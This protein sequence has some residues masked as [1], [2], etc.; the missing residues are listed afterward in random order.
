MQRYQAYLLR[1]SCSQRDSTPHQQRPTTPC[2][3]TM[4]NIPWFLDWATRLRILER[5]SSSWS[6]QSAVGGS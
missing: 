4:L 5:Y 1:F 2:T 6:L 3:E